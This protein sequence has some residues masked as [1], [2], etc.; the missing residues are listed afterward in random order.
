MK[1]LVEG[2]TRVA[3]GQFTERVPIHSH[4]ELGILAYTFNH[5][6]SK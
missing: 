3:N 6:T 4:D 2:A 5:M 1:D